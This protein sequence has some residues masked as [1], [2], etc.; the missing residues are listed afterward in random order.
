MMRNG[1]EGI[2]SHQKPK[3]YSDICPQTIKF[4]STAP[5]SPDL[6]HFYFHLRE[7]FHSAIDTEEKLHQRVFYA[8]QTSRKNHGNFEMVRQSMIT[9][10]H[11]CIGSNV[12]YCGHSS[13]T[14]LPL[15]M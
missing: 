7:Q 4:L 14:A 1:L 10:V 2:L 6:I 5:R 9:R 12:G 13:R 3:K 15:K 8:R 11:A